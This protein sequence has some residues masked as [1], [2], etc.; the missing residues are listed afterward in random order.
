MKWTRSD[1]LVLANPT[2]SFCHGQGIFSTRR[3]DSAPCNCV[4]RAIFRAC[5]RRFRHCVEKEKFMTKASLTITSSKE[6]RLT[7]GRK[8]EEYI[9]D[10]YLVSK[11]SLDPFEYRVFKYHFLLGA[12]WKLCTRK[13]G[14]D[15]GAFFHQ[16]YRIQSKLGRVF[17]ELKPYPLYPLNEYF[18]GTVATETAL[19][20][21]VELRTR[22]PRPIIPPLRTAA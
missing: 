12:D 6:R 19:S 18:E 22:G 11:R 5:Y 7:W 2:C 21:V 3:R 8:D 20:P 10:F 4:L 1:S 17:R 13:L 14:I 9:A 15:K 16:V